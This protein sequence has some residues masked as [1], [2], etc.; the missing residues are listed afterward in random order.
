D[1]RNLPDEVAHLTLLATDAVDIES[2]LDLRE[3]FDPRRRGD[4]PHG[5]RAIEAF[6]D[7]PR[8]AELLHLALQVAACHV[9]SHRIAV[10]AALRIA[11]GQVAATLA[12]G[13]HQLDLMVQVLREAR[14]TKHTGFPL[15]N[16]ENGIGRLQEKER[17]LTT[18][19]THLLCML[20]VVAADTVHA[21]YRKPPGRADDPHGR[22]WRRSEDISHARTIIRI[23]AAAPTAKAESPY[24]NLGPPGRSDFLEEAL[25]WRYESRGSPHRRSPRL[26]SISTA[27]RSSPRRS[28]P[29]WAPRLAP[30]ARQS[31]RARPAPPS[32]SARTRASRSMRWCTRA[33]RTRRRIPSK[34]SR[35]TTT[36]TSSEPTRAIRRPMPTSFAPTPGTSPSR[37]RPRPP[38]TSISRTSSSPMRWRSASTDSAASRPGPWSFP[39]WAFRSRVCCSASSPPRRPNTLPSRRCIAPPRCP[40][41]PPG[42]PCCR[43]RIARDCASM[44]Q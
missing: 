16:R 35:A 9:E 2:D 24:R 32:P 20:G 41:S 10:D 25:T 22:V 40:A 17:R 31:C 18:G 38:V 34:R 19:G 43:G 15:A 4:A 27:A 14:V 5:G 33:A 30:P 1:L 28:P 3:V 12:H 7:A 44:R 11:R 29:G 37:E 13:N 39:G 23:V 21:V 6:G 8:A 36:I 26:R 42:R